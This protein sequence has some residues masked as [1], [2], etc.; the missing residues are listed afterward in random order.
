MG[1]GI[2]M[3]GKDLRTFL[4]VAREMGATLLVRHTN[5]DSLRYVGQPGYYP[6][7]AL[8]KAKTADFDPPASLRS[9]QGRMA[10]QDYHVAGL[11]VHPGMHPAAYRPAKVGKAL[12]CWI[13]GLHLLAAGAAPRAGD[14]AKPDSWAE[15][16]VARAAACSAAWR[17]R[18][19]VDPASKHY[20]CLQLSNA[21]A[22]VGW[23]YI[24]GDYDLKDVIVPGA[25]TDNR[26]HE[27]Q[28]HGVKNFTPLL[29][30]ADFERIRI[31]LNR[32]IGADMVQHGAEAQ[33]AWH[34]EEPITAAMA[35]GTHVVLLDAMTVQRWYENLNRDVLA[36]KGTDYARDRSRMFHFGPEGMFA[37]GALPASTWG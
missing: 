33:F 5:E 29:P 12:H 21:A 15:W 11:V 13:D 23:A 32:R 26:R 14:P 30:N 35:D 2:G 16:G 34:G 10:Q 17:W 22:G 27:G 18:V 31:E 8:V 9:V 25:E 1:I 6:K 37:P 19:D 20:G 3:R 4:N 36:K 28:A 24:H 7:P